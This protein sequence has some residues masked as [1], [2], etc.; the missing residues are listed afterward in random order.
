MLIEPRQ[1]TQ[2]ALSICAND[3]SLYDP[4]WSNSSGLSQDSHSFN[5]E[6]KGATLAFQLAL[7]YQIASPPEADRK[8]HR[9]AS[10]APFQ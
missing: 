10:Y 1:R 8:D 5:C 2:S 3:L 9:S 7:S 6:L 4:L